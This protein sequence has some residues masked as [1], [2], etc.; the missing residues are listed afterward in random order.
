MA[1]C[2]SEDILHCQVYSSD[3]SNM[4]GRWVRVEG[5]QLG[6]TDRSAQRGCYRYL[7]AGR[8]ETYTADLLKWQTPNLGN[9]ILGRPKVTMP[10]DTAPSSTSTPAKT[11]PLRALS[12]HRP[13]EQLTERSFK[14]FIENR[15]EEVDNRKTHLYPLPQVVNRIDL[16]D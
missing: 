8:Q 1:G 12:S 5:C 14:N 15:K 3:G 9:N 2:S 13:I 7:V 11:R 4:D 16:L 6:Q 10:V